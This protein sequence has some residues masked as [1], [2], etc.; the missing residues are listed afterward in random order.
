MRCNEE[1]GNLAEA[2][3]MAT[4]RKMVRNVL[5]PEIRRWIKR[6]LGLNVRIGRFASLRS[7]RPMS[8]H[9]GFDRGKPVDRYYIERS[10]V[11][12]AGDIH[13]T[14][15]EIGDDAYT[16][17]FASGVEKRDVLHAEADH[18]GVTIVAD[19]THGPG[20]QSDCPTRA[21]PPRAGLS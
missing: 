4:M 13:G 14:V 16:R 17:R 18:P 10:L 12:N 19:L 5:P 2:E 20:I 1:E 6:R 15:L 9:F 3:H 7:L 8:R 21:P 11:A